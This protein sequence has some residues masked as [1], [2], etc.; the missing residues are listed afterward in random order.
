MRRVA[1]V[2]KG[3]GDIKVVN[4]EDVE[5]D[6]HVCVRFVAWDKDHSLVV[7]LVGQVPEGGDARLVDVNSFERVSEDLV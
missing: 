5:H 3:E 2:S 6:E 7:G 1:F 4:E